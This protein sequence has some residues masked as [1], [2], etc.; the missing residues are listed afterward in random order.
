MKIKNL[1]LEIDKERNMF[2]NTEL[3]NNGG[4]YHQPYKVWAFSW[5]GA[6]YELKY[7]DTSCGDFGERYVVSLY[8]VSPTGEDLIYQYNRNEVDRGSDKE[9]VFKKEDFSR[10]LFEEIQCVCPAWFTW[11]A[12]SDEDEEE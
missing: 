2:A 3:A 8:Q 7:S 1:R 11:D 5:D 10:E 4:G 9:Y 12:E 6:E